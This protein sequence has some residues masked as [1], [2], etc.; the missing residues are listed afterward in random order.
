MSKWDWLHAGLEVAN[1]L[2]AQQAKQGITEMRMGAEAD[3]NRR[4]LIEAIKNYIYAIFH[5]MEVVEEQISKDPQQTYILSK[6]TQLRFENSGISPTDLPDFQDKEY[7]SKTQKKIIEV[8]KKSK[9][10]LTSQQIQDSDT[11]IQY[12]PELPM[13]QQAISAKVAQESLWKTEDKWDKL[14]THNDKKQRYLLA[15][16]PGFLF[17]CLLLS[18]SILIGNNNTLTFIGI[19]ILFGSV[20]AIAIAKNSDPDYTKLKLKREALKEKLLPN[21]K[22]EQ[23]SSVFGE[24]SSGEFKK[25]YDERIA[26]LSSVFGEDFEKHLNSDE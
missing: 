11:A 14:S 13:L 18:M 3:T 5:D 23:I 17:S 7:F 24:L 25:V 1:L 8:I 12:I 6:I 19:I 15:G 9:E 20:G 4:L 26:F 2:T 21:D 10:K 16:I 22:W